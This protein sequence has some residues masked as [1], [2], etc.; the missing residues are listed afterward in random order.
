MISRRNILGTAA[1]TPF[2]LWW[3]QEALAQTPRVRASAYSAAGRQALVTYR[4]AVRLMTA[5]PAADLKGWTVWYKIHKF[6]DNWDSLDPA[7]EASAQALELDSIFGA[8][9]QARARAAQLL[10]ACPHGSPD[11]WSW[12]RMYLFFFERLCQHLTG[13]SDFALP[14]WD[15]RAA[16]ASTGCNLQPRQ[17]ARS[18][19][20]RGGGL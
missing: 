13:K 15:Y 12:H 14:Y 10:G 20:P 8:A 6:P 4:E 17:P 1:V 7:D 11:F 19:P 2:S 16:L 5:R 9:T 18:Y 3:A